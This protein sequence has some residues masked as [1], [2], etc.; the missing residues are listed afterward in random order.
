[1]MAKETEKERSQ[2][3]KN[4]IDKRALEYDLARDLKNEEERRE[5]EEKHGNRYEDMAIYFITTLGAGYVIFFLAQYIFN[6]FFG[7]ALAMLGVPYGFIY[8]FIHAA[9]WIMAIL[10]AYRG[11]SVLD[12]LFNR[13]I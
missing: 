9:I 3:R 8:P 10:S 12:D 2:R 4:E 1:M 6:F 13:F 11:R 7:T 5:I